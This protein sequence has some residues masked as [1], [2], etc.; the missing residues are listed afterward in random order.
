[1]RAPGPDPTKSR[2]KSAAMTCG[3]ASRGQTLR[4]R[5]AEKQAE[6]RVARPELQGQQGIELKERS[7]YL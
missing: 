2:R 3:Q 4:A 7:R 1:M 6:E 5:L